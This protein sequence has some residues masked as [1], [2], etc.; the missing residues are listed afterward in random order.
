MGLKDALQ[1]ITS[2]A[3]NVV[4]DTV[5]V[6]KHDAKDAAAEKTYRAQARAEVARRAGEPLSPVDV[7]GSV[8][9]QVR[10]ETLAQV[11]SLKQTIRKNI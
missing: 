4:A 1:N 6:I 2:L 9:A 3:T 11:D 10:D 7:A 5:A 8:L